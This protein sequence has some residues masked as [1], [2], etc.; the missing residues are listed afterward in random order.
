MKIVIPTKGRLNKQLTLTNLPLALRPHI[1]LVCPSQEAFFHRQNFSGIEVI[2]QPDP[3]ITIAQKRRW[4]MENIDTEK[5]VMLDDDLRFAVR[6]EDDPAKFLKAT[7]GQILAAFEGLEAILGPMI[8][9]AGFSAR[10][11]GIGESAQRGGW[12]YGKR[13]MYVLGYHL[14]T[15]KANA[16]FGRIETREDM[17]LTLQLFAKGFKNAVNFSF[18]VDQQF[19]NAG[20][21]TNERTMERSNADAFKLAE[22]HPGYVRVVEKE[23]K[24]SIPRQEVVVQWLKAME[25]GQR[26]KAASL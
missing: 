5:L 12:Q 19:A 1:I 14:P 13:M 15:V 9:H 2:A 23:Y 18:V 3:G 4:I 16:E 20:G 8:P 7:A 17:D 10:G 6:R 24:E 22:L 26:A 11:S 25:E 21:C